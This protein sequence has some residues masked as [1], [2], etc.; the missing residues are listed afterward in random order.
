MFV[1]N[2]LLSMYEEDRRLAAAV[3]EQVTSQ[4]QAGA[5]LTAWQGST[6]ISSPLPQRFLRSASHQA[7]IIQP[8]EETAPAA[9]RLA[10]NPPVATGLVANQPST[11]RKKVK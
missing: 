2:E 10:A 5:D 4:R 8:T 1:L 9:T 3:A 11:R 7:S 6:D